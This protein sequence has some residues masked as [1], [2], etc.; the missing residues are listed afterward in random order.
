MRRDALRRYI[1]FR[2]KVIEFLDVS[3]VWKNLKSGEVSPQTPVGRT[4]NDIAWSLRTVLLSWLSIFIDRSK[5]GMDVIKLWIELFPKHKKEIE[6]AWQ[7]I[8][9]SW[10]ILRE[11][12][13]R[14]GFHADKP[15]KFFNAR[16]RVIKEVA[17][18]HDALQ[19]FEALFKQLLHAEATELPDLPEALNEFLDELD[20]GGVPIGGT[21]AVFKRH[22]MFT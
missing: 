17:A 21:R 7:M 2:V 8:E 12:R 15:R 20:A 10:N 9:P 3:V 6:Q 4:R 16:G 14:A 5:D 13:D 22:Y 11:F 1:V 18:L 19:N